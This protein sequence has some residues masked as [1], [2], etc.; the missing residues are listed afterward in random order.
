MIDVNGLLLEGV[1][2]VSPSQL[3][4]RPVR[5]MSR[6]GNRRHDGRIGLLERL[7][8]RGLTY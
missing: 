1:P 4:Y 7:R 5:G 2:N 6:V 8:T 3:P